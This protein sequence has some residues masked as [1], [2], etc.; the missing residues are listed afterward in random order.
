MVIAF[1]VTAFLLVTN[2]AFANTIS[3]N[4]NLNVASLDKFLNL[5]KGVVTT[6]T[7]WSPDGSKVVFSWEKP[8]DCLAEV[9]LANGN[10]TNIL[11]LR[12]K[13][14]K[15]SWNNSEEVFFVLQ[16]GAV[17][18]ADYKGNVIRTF[19]PENEGEE[20]V[21]FSLSP[22]KE[23]IIV[24]SKVENGYF[25]TYI[26]DIDG[27]KLKKYVSYASDTNSEESTVSW[28][29][30]GSLVVVNKKGNLYI[31][32]GEEHEERLLYEGNT[33]NPLWFPDGKKILFVENENQLYSIDMDGTDLSFITNFGLTTS[34][35]WS[36][37]GASQF[38]ISPSGNIIAFTSSLDPANG[39]ILE[40]EPIPST[41][42]NIAAPLFIINW[43]V[44]TLLR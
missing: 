13:A 7:A 42:Q 36:F 15:P 43:M 35:F 34:Y 14:E 23:K 3:E 29:P 37:F 16:E 40:N 19:Q 18:L 31:Q 8:E 27:S 10:G 5:E 4:P 22:D 9:Y 26:S 1:M 24:T 17:V 12:S 30:D 20:C 44:P 2:I 38:S 25:Q 39:K 21:S 11:E 41:R 33:S 32:E 28:Q 6:S